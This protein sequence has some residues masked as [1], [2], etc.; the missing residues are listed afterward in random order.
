MFHYCRL[1]V[2]PTPSF[3]VDCYAEQRQVNASTFVLPIFQA[4]KCLKYLKVWY[5]FNV[6]VAWRV[7]CACTN[8]VTLNGQAEV[9]H[10]L[11]LTWNFVMK[12]RWLASKKTWREW[13]GCSQQDGNHSRSFVNHLVQTKLLSK[14]VNIFDSDLLFRMTCIFAMYAVNKYCSASMCGM[15][16]LLGYLWVTYGVRTQQH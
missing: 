2:D 1:V 12:I 15:Y 13:C 16:L 9:F 3:F 10:T 11:H 5:L 14:I 8:T 6:L 7:A 4:S